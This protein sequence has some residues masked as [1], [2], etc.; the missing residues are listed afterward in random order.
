M[1][2][3]FLTACS[4]VLDGTVDASFECDLVNGQ[5]PCKATIGQRDCGQC[6]DGF[7]NFPTSLSSPEQVCI[8]GELV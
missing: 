8:V 3:D 5:C 4:C 6:N 7:Y 2:C 1:L